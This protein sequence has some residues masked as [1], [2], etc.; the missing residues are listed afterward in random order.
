MRRALVNKQQGDAKMINPWRIHRSRAVIHSIG[1]VE[2]KVKLVPRGH[3]ITAWTSDLPANAK[4]G[5][6]VNIQANFSITMDAYCC[7]T[8]RRV[9]KRQ[10]EKEQQFKTNLE[11]ITFEDIE[12]YRASKR[13]AK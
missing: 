8:V 10:L 1:T 5:E 9:P 11:S 6:Q 13:G 2:S 3:I 4:V 7:K 12:S